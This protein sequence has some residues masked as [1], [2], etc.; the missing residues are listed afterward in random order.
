VIAAAIFALAVRNGYILNNGPSVNVICES[1]LREVVTVSKL[2][3]AVYI[4]NSVTEIYDNDKKVLKCHAKYNG[5]VTAGFDFSKI[6]VNIDLIKKKITLLLPVVEIQDVNV[7]SGTIE[8][9]FTDNKYDT[10]ELPQEAYIK[11]IKDL[12]AKAKSKD[13]FLALA[14][15]NAVGTI[16]GL[17]SP[18]VNQIDSEY[19]IDV[20]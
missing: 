7:D 18:W 19:V 8:Y 15:E 9:I 3:T 11:C 1:S 14:K 5:T 16:E 4:Y 17:V 10:E 12:K 6:D 2:S 13:D 20:K